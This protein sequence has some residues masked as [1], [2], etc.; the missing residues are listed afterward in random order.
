MPLLSSTTHDSGQVL[1]LTIMT[2]GVAWTLED[3]LFSGLGRTLTT[4]IED[5]QCPDNEANAAENQSKSIYK[6]LEAK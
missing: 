6:E 2:S 4:L 1:A 3:F 5:N